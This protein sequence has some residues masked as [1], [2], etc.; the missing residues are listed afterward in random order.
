MDIDELTDSST[1]M[2]FIDRGSGIRDTDKYAYMEGIFW[3]LVC[4]YV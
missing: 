4:I 3:T 1:S 2:I